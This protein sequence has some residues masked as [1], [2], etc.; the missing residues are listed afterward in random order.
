MANI[1]PDENPSFNTTMEAMDRTTPAHYQQFNSRYKQ[2]L[3]N[4]QHLKNQK[5]DGA[6]LVF[7]ITENGI[8]RVSYDDGK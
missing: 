2:M 8:L 1:T 6:G 3:N 5:A 4:E 7:T